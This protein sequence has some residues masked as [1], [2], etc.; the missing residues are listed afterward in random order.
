MI[1]VTVLSVMWRSFIELLDVEASPDAFYEQLR[2]A[3]R[4]RC[5]P[6]ELE[7]LR[8]EFSI[9]MRVRSKMAWQRESE[10]TAL[11]ETANDLTA[12]RDV[13]AVLS[14]IV[15]RVRQLLGADLGYLSLIDVDRGD[16]YM[17]ITEGSQ[18]PAFPTLRLPL[19]SGVLG[20]V[21]RTATPYF[22]DNYLADEE[23]VH[24]EQVVALDAGQIIATGTPE[25]VFTN[26]TFVAAYLGS[27]EVPL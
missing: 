24:L 6:E 15:R 17:R 16:C 20:R 18:S 25:G 2:V 12:I 11:Y 4:E 1:E 14:A 5:G 8:E 9:A 21:V 19:G 23:I 13:D 22:T 10:L 7:R 3:E 26:P 27:A